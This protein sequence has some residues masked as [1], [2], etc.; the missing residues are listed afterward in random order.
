M[1]GPDLVH[2]QAFINVLSSHPNGFTS[3]RALPCC[4]SLG[5]DWNTSSVQLLYSLAL[6]TGQLGET[7]KAHNK[8]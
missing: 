8:T 5:P 6:Y 2:I 1:L 4:C 7:R 3:F